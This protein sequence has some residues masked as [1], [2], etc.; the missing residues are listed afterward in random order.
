MFFGISIIVLTSFAV[1]LNMRLTAKQGM[2]DA[3]VSGWLLLSFFVFVS[4]EALSAPGWFNPLKI[5]SV[6]VLLLFAM[7]ALLLP[8][9]KEAVRICT[10]DF[11]SFR[12]NARYLYG[13]YRFSSLAVIVILALTFIH[14]LLAP[15]FEPDSMSYHLPRATHWL[16]NGSIRFYD[17]V[18]ARQNFQAP[19]Y[20]F[21]LAH[22]IA[23]THSDLF[24]NLIQWVAWIVNAFVLTLIAE[25]CGLSRRGQLLTA[26]LSFA[27]PQAISQVIVTVNDL[28]ATTAVMAFILYLIRIMKSGKAGWK[29]IGLAMIALGVSLITKYTSLVHIAGFAIPLSVWGLIRIVRKDSFLRAAKVGVVLLLVVAGGFSILLPQVTRNIRAYHDPLSG[30][31]KHMLSNV[32]LTPRKYLVNLAKHVSMHI[33][34]PLYALN[35]PVENVV[36]KFAGDLIEDPDICYQNKWY[37]TDYR[38]FT[39]LGKSHLT[40]SNPVQ[41][42]FFCIMAMVVVWKRGKTRDAIFGYSVI[43]VAFGALLYAFVF[44][45][46]PAC[47]RLQLP[48]FMLMNIGVMQWLDSLKDRSIMSKT[49]LFCS[50][51]YAV[52]HIV[53]WQTWFTPGFLFGAL[54]ECASDDRPASLQEKIRYLQ[55][56]QWDKE[57]VRRMRSTVPDE[58]SKG[59]SLFFTERNRQYFGNFYHDYEACIVYK[60]LKST[61]DYLKSNVDGSHNAWNIGLLIS[62]DHGNIPCDPDNL[63][64]HTF[65]REFLLW[66]LIDNIDGQRPLKFFH[67]GI[68]DPVKSAHNCFGEK[69]GL[70]LSDRTRES[71]LRGLA[72]DYQLNTLLTNS[73]FSV[74]QATPVP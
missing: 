6:W 55:K 37:F 17:T 28:Y 64:T 32:N 11:A 41:F 16:A 36:R 20:S 57:L 53:L 45:W 44:K 48:Y 49:V 9:R 26:L 24:F 2:R 7:V 22:L 51:S 54:P 18:I 50:L 72:N 63:T 15:S 27:I 35:R 62:S 40:A 29:S 33:A 31:P 61:I 25:E 69:S 10:G 3:I 59:Y 34:T 8:R 71:V 68:G 4:T 65:A 5:H 13:Q 52:V 66:K 56:N 39:P 1:Y 58:V 70:I 23:L 60:D 42:F 73:V 21:L 30:E 47:A 74:Y 46:Q 14:A 19:L 43:P 12:S 38:I 67:L